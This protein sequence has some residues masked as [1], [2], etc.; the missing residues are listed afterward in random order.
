METK[1]LNGSIL[2]HKSVRP[3][4]CELSD[5][6]LYPVEIGIRIAKSLDHGFQFVGVLNFLK[7]SKTMNSEDIVLSLDNRGNIIQCSKDAVNY[8]SLA[9]KV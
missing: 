8:L 2:M 9:K 1:N 7:S 4:V 5:E 3:I 6:T